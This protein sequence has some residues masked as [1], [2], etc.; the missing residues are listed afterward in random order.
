MYLESR[1][2]ELKNREKMKRIIAGV[3]FGSQGLCALFCKHC[4]PGA[5]RQTSAKLLSHQKNHIRV[6]LKIRHTARGIRAVPFLSFAR[7]PGNER[8]S[9]SICSSFFYTVQKNNRHPS[10]LECIGLMSKL[11]VRLPIISGMCCIGQSP[12]ATHP[13]MILPP[14]LQ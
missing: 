6:I 13:T 4:S 12:R 11:F 5:D 2:S 1:N 10:A 8:N 14:G 7:D 3:A 9:G